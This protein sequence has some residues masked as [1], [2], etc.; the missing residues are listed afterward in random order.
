M[1]PLLSQTPAFNPPPA[2]DSPFSDTYY[3][4]LQRVTLKPC[5]DVYQALCELEEVQRMWTV[6]CCY[7]RFLSS[8]CRIF[9]VCTPSH[10]KYRTS[11]TAIGSSWSHL[12]ANSLVRL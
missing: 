8:A 1:R 12:S 2:N 10:T 9:T 5:R 3:M 7:E 4:P 6:R 11:G